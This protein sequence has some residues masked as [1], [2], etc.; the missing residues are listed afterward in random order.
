L[1]SKVEK[2]PPISR[3]EGV[4][5]ETEES[6]ETSTSPNTVTPIKSWLRKHIMDS[7]R[8]E[9]ISSL[10]SMA[11]LHRKP[12]YIIPQVRIRGHTVLPW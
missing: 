9:D 8:P 1:C 4:D 3:P 10:A 6:K 5:H 7:E 11:E 12:V 2:P